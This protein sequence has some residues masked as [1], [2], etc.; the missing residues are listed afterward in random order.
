MIGQFR[1]K[2]GIRELVGIDAGLDE[3]G[4]LFPN[5]IVTG[6]ENDAAP[7]QRRY[8]SVI[9]GEG[10]RRILV[11]RG[12]GSYFSPLDDKRIGLEFVASQARKLILVPDGLIVEREIRCTMCNRNS[13]EIRMLE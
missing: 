9:A 10:P 6:H 5:R 13:E 8:G 11:V 2:R 1:R 12:I 4:C 3:S 7:H